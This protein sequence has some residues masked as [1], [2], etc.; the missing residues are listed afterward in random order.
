[1]RRAS[2]DASAASP[3]TPDAGG[4][5]AK[6]RWLEPAASP[7]GELAA[8]KR[9]KSYTFGVYKATK[10]ALGLKKPKTVVARDATSS[11]GDPNLA[12]SNASRR[13]SGDAS[14]ASPPAPPAVDREVQ[15]R[16]QQLLAEGRIDG[17]EASAL[18]REVALARTKNGHSLELKEA[19][20]GYRDQKMNVVV[21]ADL[22]F[23]RVHVLCEV[24]LLLLDYVK[25]KLKMHAVYRI[26]RGDFGGHL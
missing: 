23:G 4:A 12:G 14:P 22:P 17:N 19:V 25:A 15:A 9:K 24:Q 10:I 11:F 5:D 21:A 20:G 16:L 3:G 1:M 2:A 13:V 7:I 26:Y 6:A 18:L 8:I